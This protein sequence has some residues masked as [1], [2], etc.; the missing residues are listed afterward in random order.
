ARFVPGC[1]PFPFTGRFRAVAHATL[2]LALGPS[3]APFSTLAR[4]VE[5]KGASVLLLENLSPAAVATGDVEGGDLGGL[6]KEVRRRLQD[7]VLPPGY[8]IEVGGRAESQARAFQQLVVVLG[9]GIVAVVAVL[10]A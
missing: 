4:V 6:V 7:M 3:A 1:A 10:V 9:L 2:P 5:D 8:R